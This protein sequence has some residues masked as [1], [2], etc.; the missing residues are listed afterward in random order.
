MAH[1]N[2][3]NRYIGWP[4]QAAGSMDDRLPPPRDQMQGQ[5]PI[6]NL[7]D[8]VLRE[9]FSCS[10]ELVHIP[11]MKMPQRSWRW[12]WWP[13]QLVISHVCS[14]WRALALRA[15]ELWSDIQL[16]HLESW[17]CQCLETW[18]QQSAQS[19]LSIYDIVPHRSGLF[20]VLDHIVLPNLHRCR[21]LS[22]GVRHTTLQTLFRLPPGSLQSLVG[23]KLDVWAPDFGSQLKYISRRAP[24]AVFET[25]HQL[26][27]VELCGV[28][29]NADS[30]ATDL[31]FLCLPWAQLTTFTFLDINISADKCITVLRAC[32]ALESCSVSVASI[33]DRAISE[34]HTSEEPVVVFPA[35]RTFSLRLPNSAHQA[36]FLAI[37]YLPALCAFEVETA[38]I[39]QRSVAIRILALPLTPAI[40]MLRSLRVCLSLSCMSRI[41]PTNHG[42]Q[43]LLDLLPHL[44]KFNVQTTPD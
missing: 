28:G 13:S 2:S 4:F 37:F 25:A 10:S 38:V 42:P 40:R 30:P 20:N 39:W 7:N 3:S 23:I 15:P 1:S 26:R 29:L 35:L 8:D 34:I 5:G 44:T 12:C 14:S 27:R 18:L 32:V 21:Q 24:I 36:P 43:E 16:G 31:W 33:D 19:P 22:L 11:M 6:M 17:H 9:V 41:H